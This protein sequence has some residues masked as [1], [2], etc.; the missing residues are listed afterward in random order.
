MVALC[1][2]SVLWGLRRHRQAIAGP[3]R[4]LEHVA[5]T[6]STAAEHELMVVVRIFGQRSFHFG[7]QTVQPSAHIGDASRKPYFRFIGQAE[8]VR[9][10]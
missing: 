6:A 1:A 9:R 4:Y 8:H 10:L 3:P 7:S 5:T 2:V